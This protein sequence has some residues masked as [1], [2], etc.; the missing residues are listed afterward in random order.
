MITCSVKG[1][2]YPDLPLHDV[3]KIV[4]KSPDSM[5]DTEKLQFFTNCWKPTHDSRTVHLHTQVFP[6]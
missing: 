2:Q 3:S 1:R 6:N 4:N 5:S